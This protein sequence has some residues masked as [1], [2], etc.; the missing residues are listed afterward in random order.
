MVGSCSDR[1]RIVSDV[2]AVFQEFLGNFGEPFCVP[3][4]LFGDVG[5]TPLL[6][7]TL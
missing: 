5:E 2:A 1:S 3:G 4:A 6:L 7:R